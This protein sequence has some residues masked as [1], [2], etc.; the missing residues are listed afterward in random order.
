MPDTISLSKEKTTILEHF[1]AGSRNFATLLMDLCSTSMHTIKSYRVYN[2]D[3]GKQII[4]G[5][6]NVTKT[7]F[8][9]DKRVNVG[10]RVQ[11]NCI[12]CR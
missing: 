5:L 12:I 8:D 7:A 9:Q 10:Y 3:D 2:Y 1:E 11:L 4:Y 6:E